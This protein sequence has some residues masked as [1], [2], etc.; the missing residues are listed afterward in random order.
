MSTDAAKPD[1]AAQPPKNSHP[2]AVDRAGKVARGVAAAW[3]VLVGGVG[4]LSL[5]GLAVG[6]VTRLF[7]LGGRNW[8]VQ[9]LGSRMSV[10][11][12]AVMAGC[13]LLLLLT[14]R[15][16][17][18]SARA[19]R[20]RANPQGGSA[21]LE[22]VLALPFMLFLTLLMVQS[23]LLLGGNICVHYSAFCAARSAVVSIP[24]QIGGDD[25]N[26]ITVQ[27]GNQKFDR[28][29]MAAAY[30]IMPVACG[31]SDYSGTAD[32]QQL[33]QSAANVFTKWN[34][35][36]PGWSGGGALD[37]RLRYAIDKTRIDIDPP[38]DGSGVYAPGEDIR[39]TVHHTLYMS[40]PYA[41]WLLATLDS[42]DGKKLDFGTSNYGM[43][44]HATTALPNEGVRDY[45][46]IEQFPFH[47]GQ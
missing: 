43:E 15:A 41:S 19:R 7:G 26:I 10:I 31:N 25:R 45:I 47:Q 42:T 20:R 33:S 44:I 17:W 3:F 39:V 2:H 35:Q 6:P 13:S 34:K 12:F 24:R 8:L 28:V 30:A 23:S 1:S 22:F 16:L 5:A 46:D 37:R 32:T 21:M 11:A 18:I 38:A 14:A 27:D 40:V 9:A 4:V 29:K 36:V